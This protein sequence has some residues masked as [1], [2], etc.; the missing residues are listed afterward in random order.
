[1]KKI[2][3]VTEFS[4]H[5][6]EVFKYAAELAYHLKVDLSMLH[7]FKVMD[8]ISDGEDEMAHLADVAVD[9]LMKLVADN[10]PEE[11]QN[12]VKIDYLFKMGLAPET[13]METAINEEAGL[14]VMSLTGKQTGLD[15]VIGNTSISVIAKSD[16]PVLAIPPTVKF[17]GIDN[18]VYTTNFEFRDLAA[19]NFL[20]K[21][22]KV[23]DANIH[24][25]HVIE[26]DE[27]EMRVMKNMSTLRSTYKSKR[28]LRFDM[29]RGQFEKEIGRFAKAKKAD[30]L[31]MMS[32]KTNFINRIINGSS[33][34]NIALNVE[35][36]ILVIKDNAFELDNEAWEWLEILNSVG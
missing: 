36:P 19:I 35:L 30:I 32:H 24:C 15:A 6:D 33:V 3:F 14:I 18:L 28:R 10:M 29:A 2:L 20:Q 4:D 9:N 7:V 23:F 11:Y 21:W 27:N 26:K 34:K 22:A 1:M 17:E 5:A 31:T 8:T 13:I 12:K 16:V 25:L